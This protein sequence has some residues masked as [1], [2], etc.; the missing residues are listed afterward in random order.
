MPPAME[1]TQNRPAAESDL[2]VL[3]GGVAVVRFQ[4]FPVRHRVVLWSNLAVR[5]HIV[6]EGLD[7]FVDGR[8]L[9]VAL[10]AINWVPQKRAVGQFNPRTAGSVSGGEFG[11]RGRVPIP[12]RLRRPSGRSQRRSRGNISIAYMMY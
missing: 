1:A 3:V 5:E 2:E 10:P 8:A 7:L 6:D 11:Q 12:I 9:Q 4:G